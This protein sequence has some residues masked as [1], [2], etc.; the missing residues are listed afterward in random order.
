M[1]QTTIEVQNHGMAIRGTMYTP[2]VRHRVPT[3]LM[4]HGFTGSRAET[5]FLFVR[6]ARRLNEAGIAAVT[7]DFRGSGESDGSF[8]QMLVSGELSDAL[9]MVEWVQGQPFVDRS[10]FCLLGFS[11]GGLLAACV[12]ARVRNVASMVMIA[13]T[14]VDNMCRF[15]SSDVRTNE[16]VTMGAHT[17]HPDFFNDIR[18]LNPVA[19]VAVHPRP[20][21]LIQGEGDMAVP[22]S[23]SQAYVDA[24]TRRNVPLD[25][26]RMPEANHGFSRPVWQNQLIEDVTGWLKARAER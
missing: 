1:P 15:A 8:D 13:P 24:M 21:L 22:P 18:K 14:T 12:S 23:V 11:L 5:G 16:P 17:M 3:V 25:V 19:D 20:T 7:F 4:L 10:Q 2:A 26:I 6:L 9:R